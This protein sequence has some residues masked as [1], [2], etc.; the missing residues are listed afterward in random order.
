M[1]IATI[2]AGVTSRPHFAAAGSLVKVSPSVG[3]SAI[4]EYTTGSLSAI[5]N[6]AVTW[7]PWTKGSAS[8]ETSDYVGN[9]VYVRV[10]AV[11]NSVVLDIETSPSTA[12]LA[13]FR[14]D[15][16]LPSGSGGPSSGLTVA[17]EAAANF[18]VVL[19]NASQI[20]PVNSSSAVVATIQP[21]TTLN[22]PIGFNVALYRKGL[23]G[24]SFVAGGGVTI[25]TAYSLAA[26]NQYSTIS[27]LKTG[28]NEWLVSGDLT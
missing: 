21:D 8:V 7:A 23:G 17:N 18:N 26:R 11:A 4:V 1:L 2:P 28:A 10:T 22:L 14:P 3:A 5:M 9:P 19:A 12:L 6:G 27:A 20:I 13:P 16:G 24:A 15:W 25:R